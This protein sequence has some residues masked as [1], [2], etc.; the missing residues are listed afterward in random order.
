MSTF[1]Q[2]QLKTDENNLNVNKKMTFFGGQMYYSKKWNLNK[3]LEFQGKDV[4]RNI[5]IQDNYFEKYEKLQLKY[6]IKCIR[7]GGQGKGID[8]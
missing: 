8:E 5:Q 4:I 6:G 7:E 1:V 2:F 3:K